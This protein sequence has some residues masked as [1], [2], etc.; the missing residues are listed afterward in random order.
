MTDRPD[1]PLAAPR[2]PKVQGEFLTTAAKFARDAVHWVY[3]DI[4]GHAAFAEWAKANPDDFY[5][6]MFGK[7]IQRDVEIG[8]TLTVEGLLEQLDQGVI[9]DQPASATL[10][11]EE[12]EYVQ[13]TPAVPKTTQN[14]P[15]TEPSEPPAPAP[16]DAW[17][18]WA[19]ENT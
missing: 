14:D 3:E 17:A 8:G 12:A 15:Q 1:L 16:E 6:K 4:G 7:T 9:I 2:L 18:A 11:Y 13:V 19:E 10:D 5:T